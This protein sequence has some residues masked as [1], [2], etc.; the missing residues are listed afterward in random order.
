MKPYK[1]WCRKDRK[2]VFYIQFAHTPGKW[3]TTNCTDRD[4]AIRWAEANREAAGQIRKKIPT[5]KQFA[6]GFFVPGNEF[7]MKRLMRKKKS[8]A[9]DYFRAHQGRLDNYIIPEFGSRLIS[10]ITTVEIDN[11]F[12]DLESVRTKN[13]LSDNAKNKV[14]HVFRIILE[15]AKYQGYVKENAASAVEEIS[16]ENQERKHFTDIEM[17]KLF[18]DDRDELLRIWQ[19]LKWTV[20]FMIMKDTGFRPGEVAGLTRRAYYS[21]VGGIYTTGSIDTVTGQYK[22]SIKT[23][24]KGKGYKLGLLE[25]L[26]LQLLDDYLEETDPEI[27]ELIFPAANTEGIKVETSLKHFKLSARRAKVDL[28]GRTQYCLRHSFETR[29]LMDLDLETVKELMGHT[30]YRKEY[31]HRSGEDRL[32]KLKSVLLENS[33]SL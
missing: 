18:P 12:L 2:G 25:D 28:Q 27:D 1:L 9:S 5:L 17:R 10:S 11:W 23:T 26:T 22:D 7:W 32:T 6:D 21:S 3:I 15:E 19:G 8:F 4:D 13:E 16:E 20:F 30:R 14:L 31:D 29:K 24:K 33:S